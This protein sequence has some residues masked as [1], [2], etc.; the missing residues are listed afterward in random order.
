MHTISQIKALAQRGLLREA[1]FAY[2]QRLH[3]LP[4]SRAWHDVQCL[5]INC[6]TASTPERLRTMQALHRSFPASF[7]CTS[8]S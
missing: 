1:Y 2:R 3:W 8:S 7:R 4:A 5:Q 6:G